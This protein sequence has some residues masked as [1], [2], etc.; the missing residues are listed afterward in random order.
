MSPAGIL[1]LLVPFGF[2]TGIR[3]AE[4]GVEVT[5]MLHYA[6]VFL[7]VA[8]VCAILGFGVLSAV[9]ATIAKVLFVVFLVIFLVSLITGRRR[10]AL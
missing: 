6:L 9:A 7:L 8:I 1:K 3:V 10:A 5:P 4:P 2:A